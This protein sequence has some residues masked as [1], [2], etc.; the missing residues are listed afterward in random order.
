MYPYQNNFTAWND[1]GFLGQC[2]KQTLDWIKIAKYARQFFLA[3]DSKLSWQ[4]IVQRVK[5]FIDQSRPTI[6]FRICKI[7]SK[8]SLNNAW[9]YI[10]RYD[11]GADLSDSRYWN[12]AK[13]RWSYLAA[14]L[15]A[16]LKMHSPTIVPPQENTALLWFWLYFIAPHTT[17]LKY[18]H[19]MLIQQPG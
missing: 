10:L 19:K 15:L 7:W 4:I 3:T 17:V 11:K 8:P 1:V 9:T 16:S 12:K 6:H 18:C 13:I 2:R 14:S 5:S